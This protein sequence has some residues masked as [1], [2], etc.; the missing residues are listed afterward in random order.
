[1]AAL[2]SASQRARRPG[3]RG[4]AVA[5]WRRLCPELA[6]LVGREPRSRTLEERLATLPAAARLC[7]LLR[8]RE[9]WSVAA[10]A[11]LVGESP[12]QVADWLYEAREGL[13]SGRR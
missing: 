8:E 13:A 5:W 4:A 10:I 12:Q 2:S 9:A 11:A 6:A 3:T 7:L 1:M